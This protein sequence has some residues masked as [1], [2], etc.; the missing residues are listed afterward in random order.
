M[1][2]DLKER[3]PQL[4]MTLMEEDLN[5]KISKWNTAIITIFFLAYPDIGIKL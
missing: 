1:E 5:E 4:K 2:D 3:L